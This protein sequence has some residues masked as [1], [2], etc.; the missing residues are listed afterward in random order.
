[1]TVYGAPVDITQEWMGT[2]FARYGQVQDV[3]AI[4][5]KANIVAEYFSPGNNKTLDLLKNHQHSDMSGKKDACDCR[6]ASTLVMIM[7]YVGEHVPR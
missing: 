1:M 3:S 4:I 6:K 2:I 7:W 5:N